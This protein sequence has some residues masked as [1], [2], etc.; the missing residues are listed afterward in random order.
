MKRQEDREEDAVVLPE[1]EDNAYAGDNDASEEEDGEGGSNRQDPHERRKLHLSKMSDMNPLDSGPGPKYTSTRRRP[2][3][4]DEDNLPW[5]AQERKMPSPDAAALID[6][7][8]LKENL[9]YYKQLGIRTHVSALLGLISAAH[10]MYY[11]VVVLPDE[12]QLCQRDKGGEWICE[13]G[14]FAQAL[15]TAAAKQ[16]IHIY[17]QTKDVLLTKIC[18]FLIAF[19]SFIIITA[20]CVPWFL[21]KR[22]L[23]PP[24]RTGQNRVD[25]RRVDLLVMF[26]LYLANLGI[27]GNFA[28]TAVTHQLFTSIEIT[29]TDRRMSQGGEG[30][31]L[32]LQEVLYVALGSALVFILFT[33]KLIFDIWYAEEKDRNRQK[34]GGV[35]IQ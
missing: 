2:N 28:F 15:V 29:S 12:M 23:P 27:L 32:D 26:G 9:K 1:I 5:F 14:T 22:A 6:P 35:Q 10:S 13:I 19:N 31:G 20:Q 3:G 8:E 25:E 34:S 30:R 4:S 18:A 24:T 16:N 7:L 33:C 21:S 11:C 17:T